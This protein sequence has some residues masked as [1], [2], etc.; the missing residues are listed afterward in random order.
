MADHPGGG[1]DAS[2]EAG[3]EALSRGEW[4]TA[5]ARFQERLAGAG[6]CP[7]AREG[8]ASACYWLQDPPLMFESRQR[9]YRGYQARGDV[10]SAARMATWLAADFLEFRGEAAV[11]AGWLER[12]RQLLEGVRTSPEHAM[13]LDIEAHMALAVRHD[14]EAAYTAAAEARRIA[15]ELGDLDHEMLARASEGLALVARGEV[16]E[17]MRRLDGA[18][19]AALGGDMADLT[20]ISFTCC[21]VIQACERVR[22]FQRA[23]E[24]CNRFREICERWRLGTFL[25][26]CRLQYGTVLLWRGEWAL[27]E[28]EL[29]AA[30]E[31]LET[32]RPTA[33][34]AALVRLGELR[35]RQGRWEEAAALLEEARSHRLA[36]LRRAALAL[37]RGDAVA[38]EELVD[39]ALARAP[40]SADAERAGA[41]ELLVRARAARGA[42]R[43]AAGALEQ[44]RSLA[45]EIGTRT[46]QAAALFSAGLLALAG[47]EHETAI[48]R[49]REAADLFETIG[50]PFEGG[51]AR[52]E[53]ARALLAR[54][55]GGSGHAEASAALAVFERLGAARES[56]RARELLASSA[57]RRADAGAAARPDGLTSRQREVLGLVAQGMSN[58]QIAARLVLSEFTVR[59]HLANVYHRLGV[60]TRAAAVATALRQ[61]LV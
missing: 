57:S 13:L 2:L 24:W 4:E 19:A 22:D 26:F 32:V 29:L 10:R 5:R 12:A 38:A 1:G 30:L 37:D 20:A 35:R 45:A 47:D 28:A 23:S 34:P 31:D 60:S 8:L 52:L 56:E 41:L 18:A 53:L 46:V 48:R 39:Q 54:G 58:R 59:R 6:D 36:A 51:C 55:R 11:A 9:A 16:A 3:K 43:E 17:G 21:Y 14:A 33:R 15:Q 50:S 42:L 49:L 44:L 7:E 27:A 40:D 25:T 61:G